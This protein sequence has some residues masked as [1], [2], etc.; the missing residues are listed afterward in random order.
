[1]VKPTR[2]NDISHRI[3]NPIDC[4]LKQDTKTLELKSFVCKCDPFNMKIF[5]EQFVMESGFTVLEDIVNF[6]INWDCIK[7]MPD[8][9]QRRGE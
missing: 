3:N 6:E 7:A 2:P 4:Q 5:Y 9:V 8:K 1:M